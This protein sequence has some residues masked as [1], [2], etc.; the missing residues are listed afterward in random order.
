MKCKD[1]FIYCAYSNPFCLCCIMLYFKYRYGDINDVLRVCISSVL[2]TFFFDFSASHSSSF[3][4][5][6]FS[7]SCSLSPLFLLYYLLLF[8]L[9]A[10]LFR[11]LLLVLIFLLSVFLFS[12][13]SSSTSSSYSSTP[14]F[15]SSSSS[16]FIFFLPIS[17][18]SSSS[19]S[20][21]A[22]TSNILREQ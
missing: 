1:H 17:L 18:S 22:P 20:L 7:V 6:L 15:S 10:P 2:F 12:L 21:Y 4:I 19:I 9:I 16:F 8:L 5:P 13:L 14:S 3:F 11:F